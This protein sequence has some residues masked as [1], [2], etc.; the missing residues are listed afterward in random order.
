MTPD[1]ISKL[2]NGGAFSIDQFCEAH[3]ITRPTLYRL[4]K[5][6]KGPRIMRV[7]HRKLI[8]WEAAA[9]WRRTCEVE[10]AA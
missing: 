3:A 8:S 10:A 9:E 1:D 2:L 4:W 7:R 5:D 6:G